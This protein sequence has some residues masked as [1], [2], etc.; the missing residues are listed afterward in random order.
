M[1]WNTSK[2]VELNLLKCVEVKYVEISILKFVKIKVL[3]SKYLDFSQIFC[4]E[5]CWNGNISQPISTYFSPKMRWNR[6][7]MLKRNLEIRW[8]EL[9]LWVEIC[10]NKSKLLAEICW[11]ELKLSFEICWNNWNSRLKIWWNKL[12][13]VEDISTN[14]NIFDIAGR[15]SSCWFCRP[16]CSPVRWNVTPVSDFCKWNM[17]K[18]VENSVKWNN[19]EMS[20]YGWNESKYMLPGVWATWFQLFLLFSHWFQRNVFYTFQPIWAPTLVEMSKN[21]LN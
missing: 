18:S 10:W 3:K 20:K 17:L 13:F 1:R 2:Y 4:F 15:R 9:N 5:I 16:A 14:I 7:N 21:C 19:V 11:N 6:W 8:N 12:N